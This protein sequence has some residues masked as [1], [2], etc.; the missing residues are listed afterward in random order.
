V[1][2]DRL[3]ERGETMRAYLNHVLNPMHIF[4]RLR[5]MGIP[6]PLAMRIFK[7]Y[8]KWYR[9]SWFIIDLTTYYL[10]RERD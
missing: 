2:F 5:D 3:K 6:K 4:C 7:G 8:D 10:K 9:L 1:A